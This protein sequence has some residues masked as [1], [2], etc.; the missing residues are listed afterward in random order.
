MLT[1]FTRL[2]CQAGYSVD[3]LARELG[4]SERQVFRWE[5]G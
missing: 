4:Y 1:E 3:E 2:R 5:S